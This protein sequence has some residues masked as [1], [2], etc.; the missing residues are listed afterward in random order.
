MTHPSDADLVLVGGRI[1]TLS[2]DPTTPHEVTALAVRAGRILAAGSDDEMRA[3]V[4]PATRVVELDG[5]RVIPGLVDSHVHFIRAGRTWGDEVRWENVDNLTDALAA[6]AERAA[7]V[8]P[9]EWIR[10]IGGWSDEQLAEGRGPTCEEL[11]SVAPDNPVFVQAVYNY[12]VF[13]SA[14]IAALAMDEAKIASSPTPDKF[15]RRPDG[16]WNGRGNGA[17]AQLAWFYDQLP[18]PTFEE[19][20]ASTELL[21]KEFARLGIV[22]ATDGGGVNSGPD[23]YGPITEAWRRGLLRTRVRMLKHATR[24]GT[25]AEDFAGYLRFGEARFGDA[26][27]KWSGIGEII[28]YRSHDDVGKPADSSPEAIAE[29]KEILVPFARK[30]WA[31]QIHVMERA[32]LEALLDLFEEIHAEVPIDKLRWSLI[33]ANS[34][35]AADIPRL[36]ALGMGVLHQALMRFN[37]EALIAAW[38]AERVSREPELRAIL[39]SGLHLG[40]GS[41]GMRGASFSPWASLQHFITGRTVGGTPTLTGAHLLSREE[42]LAGYTRDTAWFTSEEHERGQLAPGFL[43][44]LA[45]LT[46]DYFEIPIER[47]P[48]LSSELTLLGGDVVWSS[49]ALVAATD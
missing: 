24:R 5:R 37:G 27:L 11:D 3:L 22:G 31:V 28:M 44:D 7:Q 48:E 25:E 36:Q 46:E 40:L 1:T 35:V 47:M 10:V 32:F 20:V 43:A 6:I 17:M 49:G 2:L 34:V 45:V 18:T 42:A 8:E 4:G 19:Q 29:A 9:G 30:G 33:H 23:I 13:N 38:G 41:D 26:M 16:S 39:E 21:S 15:E 14:G 12:G